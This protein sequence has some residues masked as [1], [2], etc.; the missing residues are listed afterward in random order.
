MVFKYRENSA[1]TTAWRLKLLQNTTIGNNVVRGKNDFA[2][3][4]AFLT[5]THKNPH[6]AAA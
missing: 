4:V 5:L 1:I 2:Y 3:T 6:R